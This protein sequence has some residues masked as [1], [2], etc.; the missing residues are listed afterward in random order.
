MIKMINAQHYSNTIMYN[1]E[2][3]NIKTFLNILKS[4]NFKKYNETQRF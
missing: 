4:K 3:K 1:F 2:N